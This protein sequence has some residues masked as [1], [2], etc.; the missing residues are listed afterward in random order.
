MCVLIHF[1]RDDGVAGWRV[2]WVPQDAV[3]GGVRRRVLADW[4]DLAAR[5]DEAGVRAGDPVFLSPEYRVDP[6]LSLYG[7]S[8]RFREYTHR[9]PQMALRADLHASRRHR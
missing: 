5:E 6:L 8:K 2:F 9:E 4:A 7:Q 3:R 1:E